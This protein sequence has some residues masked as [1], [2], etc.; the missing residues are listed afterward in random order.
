[1]LLGLGR[2]GKD[3]RKRWRLL[4]NEKKNGIKPRTLGP[5]HD[6]YGDRAHLNL[7]FTLRV[8]KP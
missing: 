7:I 6:E 1:M 4:D 3:S 5:A 8:F 2:S